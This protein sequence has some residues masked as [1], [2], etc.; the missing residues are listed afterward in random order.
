[1]PN[2]VDQ[3]WRGQPGI[4]GAHATDSI[5]SNL[6]RQKMIDPVWPD[7]VHQMPDRQ[8]DLHLIVLNQPAVDTVVDGCSN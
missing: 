6:I 4:G 8:L 2:S 3:R 5:G 1:L 7:P